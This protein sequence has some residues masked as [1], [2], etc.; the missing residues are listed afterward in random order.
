MFHCGTDTHPYELYHAL[1]DIERRRT[2]VRRPQTN[3][4]MERYNRTVLDEFFRI[5]LRQ[6]FYETVEELQADLDAW[7]IHYNTERPSRGYRVMGRR[8]IDTVNDYL[9]SLQDKPGKTVRQEA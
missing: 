1:N 2:K 7:L 9:K 6:K 5:A 3:R 4:F 8:P